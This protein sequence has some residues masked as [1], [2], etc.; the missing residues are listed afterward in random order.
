MCLGF[1]FRLHSF[2]CPL[3]VIYA[4][5]PGASEKIVDSLN[6]Y[7]LSTDTT[8]NELGIHEGL[9]EDFPSDIPLL[10]DAK[11]TGYLISSEG[12]NVTFT[13]NLYPDTIYEDFK[14]KLET[15][16]FIV[17]EKEIDAGIGGYAYWRRRG[18]NITTPKEVNL[19]FVKPLDKTICSIVVTY[20]FDFAEKAWRGFKKYRSFDRK[21]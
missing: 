10:P 4:S 14:E 1:Y 5:E 20:K 6:S 2:Y 12:T 18:N 9:P 11:V 7:F 17:D 13:S 16:G 8:E 15:N 19:H 3:T 21:R